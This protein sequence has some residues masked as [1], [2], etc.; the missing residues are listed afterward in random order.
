[1]EE[2]IDIEVLVSEIRYENMLEG[3]RI[4]R[5]EVEKDVKLSRIHDEYIDI[6]VNLYH[7][8]YADVF[9]YNNLLL[10]NVVTIQ[11]DDFTPNSSIT[12]LAHT[13][14]NNDSTVVPDINST[15]N[16]LTTSTTTNTSPIG[17]SIVTNNTIT[18]TTVVGGK[19]VGKGVG[20]GTGTVIA[21]TVGPS[22]VT[23]DPVTEELGVY[24][25]NY[26]FFLVYNKMYQYKPNNNEWIHPV[27]LLLQL[28]KLYYN[29]LENQNN[30]NNN[31]DSKNIWNK[32]K[33]FF[34]KINLFKYKK[35]ENSTERKGATN[36]PG[37]GANDTFSTPGK[38]ANF[39]AMECTMGK[40][41][42]FT[43]MECTPG[44]GANFMGM[45]CTIGNMGTVTKAN[46]T[47]VGGPDT[48]TEEIKL[49]KLFMNNKFKYGLIGSLIP[50]IMNIMN[51][52]MLFLIIP[53]INLTRKLSIELYMKLQFVMSLIGII[54]I[55]IIIIICYMKYFENI[56]PQYQFENIYKYIFISF[57][58]FYI[59]GILSYFLIKNIQ[60]QLLYHNSYI[61]LM[62]IIMFCCYNIN[63]SITI[64]SVMFI[65]SIKFDEITNTRLENNIKTNI[66]ILSFMLIFYNLIRFSYVWIYFNNNLFYKIFFWII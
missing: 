1:M 17:P 7:F 56:S 63:N 3:L 8:K 23:G 65:K 19:G 31:K 6:D 24:E 44:K 14:T 37:K 51:I 62:L 46:G 12:V 61:I 10:I 21:G 9:S 15:T 42:N 43:A 60:I 58:L 4:Y 13:D 64:I 16:N 18:N 41:A 55:I 26:Y 33:R 49:V 5:H 35:M 36:T 50:I 11:F 47:A 34:N 22:T 32:I 27:E 28:T 40:G 57:F 45:E 20:E 39:T 66:Q 38:G 54:P 29:S 25:M 59:I 53:L 52:I 48:V 2:I 30:N